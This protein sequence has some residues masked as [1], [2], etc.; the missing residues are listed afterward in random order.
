MRLFVAAAGFQTAIQD[1]GRSGLRKFGVTPGGALDPVP[2]RLANL[3][4]GNNETAAGLEIATG[5]VQLRFSDERLVAWGGA[6]FEVQVAG[7]GLP[8]LRCGRVYAG[9]TCEFLPAN[10]RAWLAVSGGIDVPLVLGS[11]ATD[12]RAHFGGMN[13]RTLRDGDELPLGAQTEIGSRMARQITGR[14]ASWS[15]PRLSPLRRPRNRAEQTCEQNLTAP[16]QDRSDTTEMTLRVIRG[17]HWRGDTGARLLGR[18]FR[19]AMNSD[20]MGLRLEGEIIEAAYGA[21]VSEPVAPGTIQ[22]PPDGAPIVLLADC[23]T[24]GGYPKLAHVI[25][26]D[27]AHAAQLQPMHQVR[28]ALTTLDFAQQ[29]V[30]QRERDIARFRAGIRARFA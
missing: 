1:C 20:R 30:R 19:V 8:P 12:L 10:G 2:L 6:A 14:V 25:T 23:Q 21:L 11:R 26:V 18:R 5:R 15:G 13:G 16:R 17:K 4:V 28:F 7:D 24:V 22:L 29:L 9:E 3:L 27:L